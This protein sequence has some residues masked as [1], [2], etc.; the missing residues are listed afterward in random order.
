[1]SFMSVNTGHFQTFLFKSAKVV[2]II[3]G[4]SLVIQIPHLELGD[5][6]HILL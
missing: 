1:M 5:S 3:K 4:T 6:D 2:K